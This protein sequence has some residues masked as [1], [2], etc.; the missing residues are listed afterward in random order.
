MHPMAEKKKV[1]NMRDLAELLG[2]SV[3]TVSRVLNHQTIQYRIADSTR[4][5]VIDAAS[6]HNFIPNK[7]ARGLKLEKTDTIGLIIPD[8]GNPFF[9][10]IAQ[11][12]ELQARSKGYSL[13]LSDS[14]DDH[15][16]EK[17]LID[18]LLSH[19]VDGIIIAPVGTNYESIKQTY[20]AGVP[21]VVIDRCSPKEGLPF[22]TSDNYQGGYDA[23]NYLVSMG[24]RS[25]ACIQGIPESPPNTDRVRGFRD[26]LIANNLPYD[27]SMIVG[28]NYSSE[29][30][31][32]Q[33][34]ILFSMDNPPTAIFALSNMI[35]L[36]VIKAT[37]EMGMRIP[38]NLSLISFDEQPYSAYLGTPMTTVGQKKSEMGQLAV[39]VLI[40]Y[41]LNKEQ[42]K[43]TV[44]ITLKTNL[45][46]RESVKSIIQTT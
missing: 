42:R 9:A 31:Y 34:R 45:N 38:D 35:S 20:K 8:I 13:L 43:K 15:L 36:G 23:V 32:M 25:I 28:D 14:G 37:S 40:K 17:G 12:I 24:H 21:I 1:K 46:V 27:E 10:D 11:S 2:L 41:I 26:A 22:I 3:T 39:D 33:T 4:Q 19:K 5:R 44:N 29:N 18:L 7:L 6:E 16:I 30:G